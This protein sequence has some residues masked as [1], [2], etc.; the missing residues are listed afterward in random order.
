M[1]LKLVEQIQHAS[2]SGDIQRRHWFIAQERLGR[3]SECAGDRHSLTLAS[4]EVQ[5]AAVLDRLRQPNGIEQFVAR[6]QRTADIGCTNA[7]SIG[8]D[9]LDTPPWVERTQRILIDRPNRVS[10][11]TALAGTQ[12]APLVTVEHHVTAVG[13]LEPEGDPRNCGLARPRLADKTQRC[14]CR[15]RERHRV[16]SLNRGSLGRGVSTRD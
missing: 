4:R 6:R 8:E 11:W 7:E 14:S 9:A 10:A 1:A 15:E 12:R 3:R 5:R 2:L 16:E 13:G